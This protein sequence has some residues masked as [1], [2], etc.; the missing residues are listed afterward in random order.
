MPPLAPTSPQLTVDV[1]LK[2]PE[3]IRRRLTDLTYKRFVADKV[4]MRGSPDQVQGGGARYQRSEALFFDGTSPGPVEQVGFRSEF[5]RAGWSEAILEAFVK[6]YGLEFVI[7]DLAKRRNAIDMV[8]RGLIKLGNGIVR[9]VDTV[10]MT[11]LLDTTGNGSTTFAAGGDWTT[12]ATDIIF[13][14]NRARQAIETVEEGYV[15]DTVLI[16]DAQF[17]DLMNDPDI[18]AAMPRESRDSFIQTG[19]LPS[20]LGFQ[21]IRTSRLTA[22]KVVVMNSKVAGT[23]A[24]EAPLAEEGYGSYQPDDP[25]QAPI[26]TKQYREENTSDTVVRGVRWPAMWIAEPKAIVVITGA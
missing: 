4:F 13:D 12:A 5:P 22:G 19:V 11:L 25:A 26:W 1:L 6:A 7:N 17:A 3:I 20:L 23:I 18:R 8:E 2:N 24:D 10:A 16:N 14:L 9:F 15:A 21:F